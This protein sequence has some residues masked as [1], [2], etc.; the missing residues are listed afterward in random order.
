V[1]R[2]SSTA[3]QILRELPPALVAKN[4]A[5]LDRVAQA[6]SQLTLAGVVPKRRQRPA[7]LDPLVHVVGGTTTVFLPIKTVSEA[8]RADH[9]HWAVRSKRAK[10]QRTGTREAL[11][12]KLG[13]PFELPLHVHLVRVTFGPGLDSDNLPISM[14]HLRDGIADW[15]G[16][17]DR[18]PR[19]VWTYDQERGPRGTNG[20]RAQFTE[21]S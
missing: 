20:V 11:V 18:D 7:P 9:E 16:I 8:N 14:K 12:A 6:G 3:R 21:V 2:R 4:R 15:L 10:T 1:S 5:A 19:V 17:N 13:E